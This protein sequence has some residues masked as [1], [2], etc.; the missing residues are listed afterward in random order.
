MGYRN[1]YVFFRVDLKNGMACD[2]RKSIGGDQNNVDE[3][4][5]G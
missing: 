4:M 1:F 5:A 2:E 3:E